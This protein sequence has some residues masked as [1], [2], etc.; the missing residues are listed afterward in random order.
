MADIVAIDLQ[1]VDFESAVD[2]V[3]ILV[4]RYLAA[5]EA[6]EEVDSAEEIG[7]RLQNVVVYW[8]RLSLLFQQLEPID[9]DLPFK[10]IMRNTLQAELAALERVY[11]KLNIRI[12]FDEKHWTKALWKAARDVLKRMD[13]VLDQLEFPEEHDDRL[14]ITKMLADHRGKYEVWMLRSRPIEAS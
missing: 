12:E 5:M 11:L 3:D 8:Q 4:P 7:S 14:L 13:S 1:T 6:L 2:E 9:A 10:D